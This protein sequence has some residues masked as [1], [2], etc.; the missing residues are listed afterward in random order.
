MRPLPVSLSLLISLTLALAWLPAGAAHGADLDCLIQAREIVTV[1]APV[2]G[3]VEKMM[4]D[5]GDVVQKGTVLAV[6]ESSAERAAMAVA[7]ARAE[8]EA[9][10]RSNQ[11]RVDFGLRRL[12]RTDDMYKKDLIPLKELDEAQ[13]AKILAELSLQEA[14]ENIRLAGLEYERAAV[15][16]DLRTIKSPIAGVVVDRLRHAGEFTDREHPIVKIARLD[17]LRVEVFAPISLLGRIA[18]G[19]RAYVIPE[20]PLDRTLEATVAVVDKVVDAASSTFGVRLEMP[21]PGHRIPAGLKCK[22][23]FGT[24]NQR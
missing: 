22:A 14:R 18:L 5:R 9:A 23:R 6:L 19:Q 12:E 3:V 15:M 1:S 24:G 2:E 16:L 17:P 4:V 13:T 20:A 11:V 8:Q 10:L 7:R 21:N